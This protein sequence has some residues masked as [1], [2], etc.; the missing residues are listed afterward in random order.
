MKKILGIV[1]AFTVVFVAAP[2]A[3]AATE[4]DS[5]LTQEISA[6][7]LST[8]IRNSGGT[9]VNNPAFAMTQ[10]TV[11]TATQTVTGTFGAS[12]TR[13]SVD[14]PN[15]ATGGW[16]LALN[17]EDPGT[18]TWVDGAKTYP[19]NG[20]STTGQLSVNPNAGTITANVGGTTGVTKGSAASFSGSSAITLMQASNTAA[21]YWNGYIVGIGLSQ[22]IPGS[23]PAGN[24]TLNLV[25][26]VTAD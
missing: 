20:N 22:V 26:T 7:T 19:Y 1:A 6:G 18:T 3:F 23:Q 5:H 24:Y 2:V 12:E 14:N 15:S 25:Q 9:V 17:A 21:T 4:A 16:T 11:S 8:S 10:A 13:I